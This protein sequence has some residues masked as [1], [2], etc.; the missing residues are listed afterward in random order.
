MTMLYL[1]QKVRLSQERIPDLLGATRL[2]N[3]L[4][5]KIE[6]RGLQ[7][8][9]SVSQRIHMSLHE[10]MAKKGALKKTRGSPASGSRC[11]QGQ[12][13]HEGQPGPP[14]TWE[15]RCRSSFECQQHPGASPAPLPTD[16]SRAVPKTWKMLTSITRC[17]AIYT[18]HSGGCLPCV[19]SF[20]PQQS[21]GQGL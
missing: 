4:P 8:K 7:K 19:D 21:H 5:R 17:T 16:P 20:T 9:E 13:A 2:L 11:L 10:T 14:H 15:H 3:C 1:L 18:E 12:R 6:A